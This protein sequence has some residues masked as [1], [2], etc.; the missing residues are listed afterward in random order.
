MR[1]DA[2]ERLRSVAAEQLALEDTHIVLVSRPLADE[3]RVWSEPMQIMA[4]PR[5]DGLLELVCRNLDT[6]REDEV[7]KL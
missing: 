5:A 2:R 4:E 6:T 3:L 1:I 7:R